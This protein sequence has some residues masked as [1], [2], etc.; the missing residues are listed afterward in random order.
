[1]TP[2]RGLGSLLLW[3]LLGLLLGI[4]VVVWQRW[5]GE[6]GA[7]PETELL[8]DPPAAAK[9]RF[10]V[11]PAPAPVPEL[12]FV[13]GAGAPHTLADFRGKVVLLNIWATWCAPCRKEMPTLDRL[14]AQLGGPEFQV[15]AL[16][17]D[18]AGMAPVKAFY[19][20][21]GLEHLG[22]YLDETA[23]AGGKLALIGVPTTLIIDRQGREL[24]RRVGEAEWDSPEMVAFLR[25]VIEKT[26][27]PK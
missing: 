27:Q 19:R 8:L 9:V 5:A 1:M 10:A 12:T 18:Q 16:S 15:L 2:A 7:P 4:A 11:S 6:T 25:D 13:D 26:R 14:Q 20:E 24:G 23:Q 17:I 22:I 3:G 21:I